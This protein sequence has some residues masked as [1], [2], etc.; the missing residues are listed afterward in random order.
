M[1]ST[2]R[3]QAVSGFPGAGGNAAVHLAGTFT[4]A[5]QK[6]GDLESL[7]TRSTTVM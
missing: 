5:S 7:N 2:S 3:I 4:L 1:S 6:L